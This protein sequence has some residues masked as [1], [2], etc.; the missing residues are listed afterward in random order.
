M[1][2]ADLRWSDVGSWS[3]LWELGDK[4]NAGNV[5][6]G[7]VLLE[8]SQHCYVRSDGIMTA[9]VGLTD[10]VVVVREDAV[11]GHASGRAQDVKKV[12]DRLRAAGRARGGGP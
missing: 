7:D 12:V 5:A 3:A 11:A 4:D 6:I 9:V 2:L 8:G 1:V 10:A